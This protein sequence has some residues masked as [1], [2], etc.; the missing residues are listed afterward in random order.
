MRG[1][2]LFYALL[3]FLGIALVGFPVYSL[4]RP[5]AVKTEATATA[6][7]APSHAPVKVPIEFAFTAEPKSMR[8]K[9][10]GKVVWSVDAPGA[11]TDTELSL[12]WPQEGV[13]LLVEITWPENTP[14]AAARLTLTDSHQEEQTRSIWGEG[15]AS[16]VLTFR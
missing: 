6:T 12:E 13:D 3:A 2:P 14:L 10:L 7:P 5:Y 15:S 9:H 8:V 11:R 4:T 16:E 1:S